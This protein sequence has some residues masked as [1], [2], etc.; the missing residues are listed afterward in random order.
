MIIKH[1]GWLIWTPILIAWFFDFL[2][3]KKAP[4]ISF[5]ILVIVTLVAGG[6]L[7]IRE[8]IRP[9]KLSWLL[10][11]P[12]LFFSIMTI[13]REEPFTT[14]IN[15]ML[16]VVSLT[17]LAFTYTGGRW[18]NYAISDYVLSFFRFLLSL[19]TKPAGLLTRKG[20][21]T[22]VTEESNP[23]EIPSKN[24]STEWAILRG[25][26]LTLPVILLLSALLAAADPIF[27]ESFKNLLSLFRIES[28]G[29]YLFRGFY[30]LILAYLLA[31]AY[32]HAIH[33]SSDVKLIGVDTPGMPRFL[34]WIEG[35]IM[36]LGIDLLFA[37]FVGIQF[38]YFFGGQA[39]IHLDGFTY[40]EYARRGFGELVAVAAITLL[41]MQV[42][43]SV[44]KKEA[45]KESG[46]FTALSV[47]MV[48]LVTVILVS[49]FQRLQLYE[50]AYGF[51]RLRTYTHIFIVWIGILLVIAAVLAIAGRSRLFALAFFLACFGFGVN[52]NVVNV[53]GLIARLNI[54]QAEAEV[55]LDIPYLMSLSEDAIPELRDQFFNPHIPQSKRNIVGG[56]LA[57]KSSMRSTADKTSDLPWQSYTW[58]REQGNRILAELEP[59]LAKYEILDVES[60]GGLIKLNDEIIHCYDYGWD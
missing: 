3:W 57:C 38:K 43:N 8:G 4:G 25:I 52:L 34:G 50:S 10:V 18:W 39:N 12:A 53:D 31:G 19:F 41:I 20:K 13:F 29:E 14:F 11:I 15:Y 21:L 35:I 27:N 42:L 5:P 9:A 1:C 58:S 46:S 30:I 33:S 54:R 24:R 48:L 26:L 60:T 32:L 17:I 59:E 55:D 22:D 45:G 37:I 6:F 49:A 28:L 7:A 56:V 23:S 47:V 36:L 51:S 44:T 2:F 40:A 16:T